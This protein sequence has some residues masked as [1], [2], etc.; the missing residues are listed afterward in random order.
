MAGPLLAIR[1]ASIPDAAALPDASPADADHLAQFSLD[2]PIAGP[3][4]KLQDG[5]PQHF[6]DLLAQCHIAAQD[7]QRRGAATGRF[8]GLR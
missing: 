7:A 2:Q 6:H 8:Q 3:E 1:P 4:V 5:A